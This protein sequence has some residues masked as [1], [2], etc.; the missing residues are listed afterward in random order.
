MGATEM[1]FSSKT[2]D[3]VVV[4][5]GPGHRAGEPRSFSRSL[6]HPPP[7]GHVVPRRH[8][9]APAK[10]AREMRLV[11][12]AALGRHLRRGLPFAQ[13]HLGPADAREPRVVRGC[14]P[15]MRQ[16]RSGSGPF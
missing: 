5:H 1:T 11:G 2:R 12:E 14:T 10:P 7:H 4:P 6:F 8:A 13:Q 9:E 3:P 15:V 16:T